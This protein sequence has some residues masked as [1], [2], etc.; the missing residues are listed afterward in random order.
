MEELYTEPTGMEIC[1]VCGMNVP[2]LAKA[3]IYEDPESQ[4]GFFFDSEDCYKQFIENP[5]KFS[6]VEEDVE[7]E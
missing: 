4:E 5:E 7:V 2:E 3:I 1:P 6:V